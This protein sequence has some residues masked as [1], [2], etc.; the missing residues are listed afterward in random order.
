MVTKKEV[1]EALSQCRDPEID[2]DIVN[3]GL[4]YGIQI[5]ENDINLKLTMTSPMCPVTSLI[6]ADVQMRLENIPG[7]GHANIE[8]VWDPIWTPEMMSDELKYRD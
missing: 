2:A 3:L 8:L 6:L 1:L 7:I 4:I 5:D